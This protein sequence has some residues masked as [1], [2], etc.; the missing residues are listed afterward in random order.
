[1]SSVT[2]KKIILSL[3][4]NGHF[5]NTFGGC[6]LPTDQQQAFISFQPSLISGSMDLAYLKNIKQGWKS[7]I[8]MNIVAILPN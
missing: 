3:D 7:L 4:F 8:G 5:Y 2:K 1:V 6:N